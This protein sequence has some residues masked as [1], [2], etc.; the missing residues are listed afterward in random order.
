MID[1]LAS[2]IAEIASPGGFN[3]GSPHWR[4]QNQLA[5]AGLGMIMGLI[6]R[7]LGFSSGAQLA[8]VSAVAA[9][10]EG[11]VLVAS[12][13]SLSRLLKSVADIGF[14]LAGSLVV[15]SPSF[16]GRVAMVTALL[17]L[18]VVW[19]ALHIRKLGRSKASDQLTGYHHG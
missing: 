3:D 14:C 8:S 4:A 2:L 13:V 17:L 15:V 19:S 12:G 1:R 7:D 18:L 5:H 6:C 11:T 9:A 10:W 16:A